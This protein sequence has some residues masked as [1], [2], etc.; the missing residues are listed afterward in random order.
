MTPNKGN[1]P[2]CE[3]LKIFVNI[4]IMDSQHRLRMMA[5]IPSGP[6]LAFGLTALGTFSTDSC[7][8]LVKLRSM[9]SLGVLIKT[10][11]IILSSVVEIVPPRIYTQMYHKYLKQLNQL[12]HCGKSI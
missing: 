9:T 11:V 2:C 10:L 5:G 3:K 6:G 12:G 4:G 1:S 7:D 8:I